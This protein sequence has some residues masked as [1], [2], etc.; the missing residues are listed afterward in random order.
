M[1]AKELAVEALRR[2]DAYDEEGFLALFAP[3]CEWIVP[4]SEPRRGP[5]EVREHLQLFWVGFPGFHHEI[6]RVIGAGDDVAV[7]EGTWHGVNTGPLVMPD[8]QQLPATGRPV[9][10]RFAMVGTRDPAS[11]LIASGHLYLDQLEFLGQLG[12]VPAPAG[13]A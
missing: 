12:L 5:D 6:D 8:G 9:A 11:G 13:A 7:V 1:T 2:T 3:D 10:L 4:G